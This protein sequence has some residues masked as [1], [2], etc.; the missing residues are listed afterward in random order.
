MQG[1]L[2]PMVSVEDSGEC[3]RQIFLNKKKYAKKKVG[4][5]GHWATVDGF[6]KMM[7]DNLDGMTFTAT[8]VF[9]RFRSWKYYIKAY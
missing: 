9:L 2:L 5:V 8:K 4:L 1:K 6:A 3:I 7:T